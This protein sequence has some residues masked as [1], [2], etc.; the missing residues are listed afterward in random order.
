ML[1][2]VIHATVVEI[3]LLVTSAVSE[4]KDQ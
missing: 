2:Y 4:E 1:K 3:S